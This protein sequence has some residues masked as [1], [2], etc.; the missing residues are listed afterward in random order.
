MKYL[1]P[2]LGCIAIAACFSCG[3]DKK[4]ESV[5]DYETVAM[6]APPP[7]IHALEMPEIHNADRKLI[8]RAILEFEVADIRKAY[9]SV[10]LL[11]AAA[12]GYVADE[13]HLQTDT[14]V[15][16]HIAL[17]VP[18]QQFDTF[19]SG[20]E[21]LSDKLV[22]RNIATQDVTAEVQDL[23]VRLKTKKA[24]EIQYHDILGK[25]KTVK[26]MLDIQEQLGIVR[27]EIELME[28]RQRSMD[29]QIAYSLIDLSM[30]QVTAPEPGYG[31][32]LAGALG[33]GWQRLTAVTLAIIG[34]WHVFMLLALSAWGI[35][36]LYRRRAAR[37]G[38]A[39]LPA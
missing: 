37:S 4:Q 36:A 12:R 13:K 39:S 26:D 29:R 19:V 31:N 21:S 17:R 11:A 25:A 18:E 16:Q 33:T 32:K 35:R 14:R 15:E 2:A 38:A 10:K 22:S 24:V 6:M 28:D 8:R 30:Y 34:Y 27:E 7:A 20:L 9:D 5:A 3:G 1:T 23:A